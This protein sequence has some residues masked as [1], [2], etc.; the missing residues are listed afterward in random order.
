MHIKVFPS[1]CEYTFPKWCH[2]ISLAPAGNDLKRN[3]TKA[4]THWDSTKDED[5]GTTAIHY[6]HAVEYFIITIYYV[7][8]LTCAFAF[9]FAFI[10]SVLSAHIT[11]P[12][13]IIMSYARN[14]WQLPND[15]IFWEIALGCLIW[16][17]FSGTKNLKSAA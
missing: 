12:S 4:R 3:E 14:K 15:V 2:S 7:H 1:F 13:Y 5:T 17:W 9:A 11:L 10:G 8:S 16:R 6:L